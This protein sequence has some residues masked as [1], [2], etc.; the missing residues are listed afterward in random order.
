MTVSAPA[1]T[2]SRVKRAVGTVVI[3]WAARVAEAQLDA[4]VGRSLRR[5]RVNHAGA[6]ATHAY[7]R[8]PPSSAAGLKVIGGEGGQSSHPSRIRDR[9]A[10]D[11]AWQLAT[12]TANISRVRGTTSAMTTAM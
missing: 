12:G 8:S 7:S 3:W 5:R 4:G 10:R 9:Q 6:S 11:L 2:R 1:I